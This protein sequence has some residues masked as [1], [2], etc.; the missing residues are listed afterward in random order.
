MSQ[1]RPGKVPLPVDVSTQKQLFIDDHVIGQMI[2]V[3][4]ELNQPVK[5][6]DNPII[7]P[8]APQP[9]NTEELIHL[10]DSVIHDEAE[11]AFKMWYEANNATRSNAAVAYA[12]STDGLH[13]DKPCRNTVS[14]P[15]WHEPAC[16]PGWN[17]FLLDRTTTRKFTELVLC[18]FKDTHETDP[19]RRYKMVY[20]EDDEG[21]GTGSVWSAF[22]A[23]GITWSAEQSIIADADSFHSVLWDPALGKYVVHSR[24]NRNNHP[25]LPPQR[26]V[27]QSESED[28]VDWSTYG[29]S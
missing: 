23:D 21:A 26:Q 16:S 2:N 13:W 7:V 9:P 8:P 14:F 27:L 18:A 15:E 10:G 5:H 1:R 11:G 28:F 20:R 19:A 12:T 3:S 22:S 17:N 4:Q 6:A 24:F 29:A 25:S